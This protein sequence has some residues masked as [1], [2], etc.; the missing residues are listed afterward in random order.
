LAQLCGRATNSAEAAARKLDLQAYNVAMSDYLTVVR[1]ELKQ[2]ETAADILEHWT[3]HMS[4]ES[5]E[6]P[7]AIGQVSKLLDV[8]ID[9]IRNAERNGLISIPRNSYNN[10]RLF[11]KRESKHPRRGWIAYGC[12]CK[13]RVAIGNNSTTKRDSSAGN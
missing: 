3:G 7:L 2:A 5:D 10:Y 4:A 11:G 13:R 1:A 6:K 9:V 12:S 8:S